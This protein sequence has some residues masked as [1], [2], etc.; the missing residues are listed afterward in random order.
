M[1][2]PY[3]VPGVYYEP[4]PRAQP[5]PVPRTDV[6]GFIGF[7]PRVRD[8]AT[9]TQLFGS[10]PTGHAFRVDIISFLLPPELAGGAR[11]TAPAVTDLLLSESVVSI[12]IV[13]GGSI[14]Y[15]LVAAW[16]ASRNVQWL[17]VAGPP[18]AFPNSPAATDEDIAAAAGGLKWLRIADIHV[19]RSSD[20][21]SVFPAVLPALPPARCNDW[22]D[23]ALRFGGLP[24]V[25][26]GTLLARAV[27]AFFAN[28]GARCYIGAIRRPRFDDSAGL[29]SALGDLVGIAGSSE[30]D[31]TGLERLL[32][33]FEVAI[34]DAPDLYSRIVDP[35]ARTAPVPRPASDA[36]FRVCSAIAGPR[37]AVSAAGN[38]AAGGPVF[39]D[40]GVLA[41]QQAMLV[42][43]APERWRVLL[44][45]TAPVALD[46]LT[47]VFS[48]P[49]AARAVAWRQQ[50]DGVVDDLSAS[51]AAFYHPWALTQDKVG[52]PVYELPPTALAAGIIARRD[53]ARGPHIAPANESLVGVVG[54]SPTVDEATDAAIYAPPLNI[55]PLRPFPGLGIQLWGARTLSG[56]LWM[57]YLPVRRCLSAIERKALA[58]LR[59]LVFEPNTPLLWFQIT[60]AV[61]A[62]LVPVFDAGALRGDTPEQS[63]YVVCDATNN[64]PESIA[65]GQVLCEVGVAIAA[66]AE[67]IVFRVGRREGVVEVL[68]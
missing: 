32:C 44:L 43:C 37:T 59:P 56:D 10:P 36:C 26:D 19:R 13:P 67:F 40:A 1:A 47:G 45:L 9:P 33:I 17:V 27:R 18:S 4:R 41:T 64:P 54:L 29:E 30:R 21:A 62:I 3:A 66:P 20:G 34:V 2:S 24:A 16:D 7:E 46:P 38:Y 68:E 35:A 53:L 51:V 12:P 58:A 65:A 63:Y 5:R 14:K 42:R 52:T 22:N 11:L 23:F 49:T 60:Q 50:L 48:G 28:G 25:D 57:R 31:A 61:L 8:G 39:A 55:N 6:V 15:A